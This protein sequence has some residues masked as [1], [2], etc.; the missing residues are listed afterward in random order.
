[1]NEDLRLLTIV[2]PIFNTPIDKLERCL[3]S[4]P[5]HPDVYISIYDDYTTDY[6]V[7]LAIKDIIEGSDGKLEFLYKEGNTF[8]QFKDNH[9]LGFVRNRSIKDLKDVS[10]YVMFLD[11]DDEVRL[12]NKDIE[13]LKRNRRMVHCYSIELVDENGQIVGEE[14]TLKYLSQT[15]IPYFITPNIYNVRYLYANGFYFDESRRTFEDVPFSTKV[16]SDL[17]RDGTE[18]EEH[19]SMIYVYHLDGNNSLTRN[20]KLEKMR[21]A[22]LYWIDWLVDYYKVNGGEYIKPYIFNRIRYEAV[23]ALEL[24]MTIK[25]DRGK[26][27][28]ITRY[29]KPYN[30]DKIFS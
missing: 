13:D 20:D 25:S 11:S 16:W 12:K 15:M 10:E 29:L 30:I 17:L 1:M 5:N 6:C 26:Y 7:E 24:E 18:W 3:S 27:N 22:L 8:H 28:Y 23:K 21:D 9:G 2:I 19:D 4:I 14:N